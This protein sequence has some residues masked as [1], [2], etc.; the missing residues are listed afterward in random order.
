M[1]WWKKVEVNSW[2]L[3]TRTL[4]CLTAPLLLF[5][6]IKPS[7][8][9]A[10]AVGLAATVGRDRVTNQIIAF[11]LNFRN[12]IS[13]KRYLNSQTVWL[14]NLECCYCGFDHRSVTVTENYLLRI[15]YELRK[16]E[17]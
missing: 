7:S 10:F 6:V 2:F 4:G 15:P 1:G 8:E 14:I 5:R 3:M 13:V 11:P 16:G 12:I 17:T 9:G